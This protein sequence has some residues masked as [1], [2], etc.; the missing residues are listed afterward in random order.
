[1]TAKLFRILILLSCVA[2]TAC[3]AL[4]AFQYRAHAVW[5]STLDQALTNS[6]DRPAA[7]Q[8]PHAV[9]NIFT[10]A[11]LFLA[12]AGC[13]DMKA[14]SEAREEQLDREQG[15]GPTISDER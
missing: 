9:A 1:M 7:H 11:G 2:A 8:I 6:V 13:L 15:D 10:I 5:S 14:K 4:G 12:L 3:I